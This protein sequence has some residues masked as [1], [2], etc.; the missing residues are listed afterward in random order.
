MEEERVELLDCAPGRVMDTPREFRAGNFRI[1]FVTTLGALLALFLGFASSVIGSILA[2]TF[3][4]FFIG[5]GLAPATAWFRKKGVG[6]AGTILIMTGVFLLFAVIVVFLLVPVV[7]DQATTLIAG[8]PEQFKQIEQQDWFIGLDPGLTG[9]FTA[10]A[11]WVT[12]TFSD[13]KTWVAIGGGAFQVG[14]GLLNG[15]LSTLILLVL[16]MHFVVAL[17]SIKAGFYS[18]IPFARRE[19]VVV[20]TEEI[21]DSVGKFLRGQVVLALLNATFTFILLTILRVPSAFLL[22]ILA[23]PVTI[24]PL[25]GSVIMTAIIVTVCL[26]NSPIDAII[27]L[28]VMIVYMQ[29]ESL[30]LTPRIVGRAMKIPPY[31]IILGTL[32]GGTL[33]GLLGVLIAGP[34]IASLLLITRAVVVRRR[35]A[36]FQPE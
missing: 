32:I 18:L 19:G 28:V 9:L 31:F 22:A 11:V 21:A 24:I 20:I 13:P 8:L 17:P 6:T 1:G 35:A 16:T 7:W 4:A 25:V 12:T 26:F 36:D 27:A 5:L 33:L 2:L 34:V 10:F 14:A 3:A 29:V 15:V 30:A 23:F